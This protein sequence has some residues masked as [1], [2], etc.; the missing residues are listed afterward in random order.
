MTPTQRHPPTLGVDFDPHSKVVASPERPPALSS[1][2]GQPSF[3]RRRFSIQEIA[4]LSTES[5]RASPFGLR[6]LNDRGEGLG[7]E[8]ESLPRAEPN[9]CSAAWIT[10]MGSP[11]AE[12]RA[13]ELRAG[14]RTQLPL[15]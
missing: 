10:A 14:F 3:H 1:F 5:G 11:R 7:W 15:K 8:V 12:R 4:S 6:A 13:P 9:R 2:S